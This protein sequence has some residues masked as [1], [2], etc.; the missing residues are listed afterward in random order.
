MGLKVP[1]GFIFML[2]A[3]NGFG[4]PATPEGVISPA[5][6]AYGGLGVVTVGFGSPILLMPDKSGAD[7]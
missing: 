3:V 1:S 6:G 2:Y 7:F 4:P 5:I